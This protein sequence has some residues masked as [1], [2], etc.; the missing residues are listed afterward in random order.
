[1]ARQIQLT[2]DQIVKV[3]EA[4]HEICIYVDSDEQLRVTCSI[5]DHN[6]FVGY[7]GLNEETQEDIYNNDIGADVIFK[8]AGEHCLPDSSGI[9]EC[10]S[11]VSIGIQVDVIASDLN[12][13]LDQND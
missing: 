5:C 8:L 9:S 10:N 4:M 6:L 2:Q 12:I 7:E 1:M 3:L 11:L 13:D